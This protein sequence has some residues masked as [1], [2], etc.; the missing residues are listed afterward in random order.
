MSWRSPTMNGQQAPGGRMGQRALSGD[1]PTDR[2]IREILSLATSPNDPKRTPLSFAALSLR[3]PYWIYQKIAVIWTIAIRVIEVGQLNETAVFE[4]ILKKHSSLRWVLAKNYIHWN[5][6]ELPATKSKESC[7]NRMTLSVHL[8]LLPVGYVSGVKKPG[9][10]LI[11]YKISLCAA[12][13][14]QEWKLSP[15]R[16]L[17]TSASSKVFEK[18]YI[19]LHTFQQQ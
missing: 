3:S 13:V 9:S 16:G 15:E 7:F 6:G 2:F 5:H 8:F 12:M 11:S 1:A 19:Y 4:T 10:F 18:I 17:P 14:A